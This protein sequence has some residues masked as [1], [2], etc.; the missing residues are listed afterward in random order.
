MVECREQVRD[1]PIDLIV[2]I[3]RSSRINGAEAPF[4][5][6]VQDLLSPGIAIVFGGESLSLEFLDP[7]EAT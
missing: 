2:R 6:A 7:L 4:H 5:L 3:R 1:I